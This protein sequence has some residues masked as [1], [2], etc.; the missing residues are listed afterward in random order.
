MA[1][2]V[3]DFGDY[4]IKNLKT[5]QGRE[6]YGYN[7]NLYRQNKKIAFCYDDASGGMV[8]IDWANFPKNRTDETMT[9]WKAWCDEEERLLN[10]H[11]ST[12]PPIDTPYPSMPTME[13]NEEIFL[14]ELINRWEEA[15]TE[16]KLRKQ[17]Q[18]KTLIRLQGDNEYQYRI[19]NAPLDDRLRNILQS[20]HGDELIEIINDR[21]L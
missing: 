19:I 2:K 12:L 3:T 1:D 18:T 15:K 5:F 6:G 4:S 16:R 9:E 8:H 10:E 13:V 21:Y 17:C 14:D 11:L 20:R 7:C